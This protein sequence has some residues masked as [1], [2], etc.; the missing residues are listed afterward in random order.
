MDMV[1]KSP[2]PA[3]PQAGF[4]PAEAL[5]AEVADLELLVRELLVLKRPE[6]I[7][8][9]DAATR[10]LDR[11]SQL[12]SSCAELAAD[13]AD[14][15]RHLAGRRKA[16]ADRILLAHD[17]GATVEGHGGWRQIGL[18]EAD[19]M[20]I[21]VYLGHP[22]SGHEVCLVLEFRPGRSEPSEIRSG[23]LQENMQAEP[24]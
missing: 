7:R 6:A 3:P 4:H 20:M 2:L 15:A 9:S 13:P 11:I 23:S 18:P 16:A 24:A 12:G 14:H 19:M 8:H 22:V 17:F 1:R 10:I 21:D 5:R